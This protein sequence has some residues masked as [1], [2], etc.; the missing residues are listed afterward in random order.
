MLPISQGW[1]PPPN[2]ARFSGAHPARGEVRDVGGLL[3]KSPRAPRPLRRV[4]R[5]IVR[6]CDDEGHGRERTAPTPRRHHVQVERLLSAHKA[7]AVRRLIERAGC[8]LLFLPPYSP[9]L[10][11]IEL[12]WSKLKQL[13]RGVGARSVDALNAALAT[14]LD[15]ITAGDAAGYFRHCGYGR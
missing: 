9:D 14:L 1:K 15:A 3:G 10:N 4:R 13:L 11:P 12:A 8:T 5:G 2:P 6:R 7:P